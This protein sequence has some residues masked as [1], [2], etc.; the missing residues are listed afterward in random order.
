MSDRKCTRKIEIGKISNS[1]RKIKT[2]SLVEMDAIVHAAKK[3]ICKKC[4]EV[5][6]NFESSSVKHGN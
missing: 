3:E 2:L 4:L 5:C 1:V 6:D